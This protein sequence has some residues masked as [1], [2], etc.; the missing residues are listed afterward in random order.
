MH[1][2]SRTVIYPA[3]LSKTEP[4][5]TQSQELHQLIPQHHQ[6]ILSA[7]DSECSVGGALAL[8]AA[9]A[10]FTQE[11]VACVVRSH[12]AAPA[13]W[14]ACPPDLVSAACE[15]LHRNESVLTPRL[16]GLAP[17]RTTRSSTGFWRVTTFSPR[18]HPPAAGSVAGTRHYRE[19]EKVKGRPLG[20]V[21]KYGC[22]GSSRCPDQSGMARRPPTAFKEKSRQGE[23]ELAEE[24]GLTT[25]QRCPMVPRNRRQRDRAADGKDKIPP[26]WQPPDDNRLKIEISNQED[27]PDAGQIR[28]PMPVQNPD[29][30]VELANGFWRSASSS[31]I[32]VG[33]IV[34]FVRQWAA[35]TGVPVRAPAAYAAAARSPHHPVAWATADGSLT[36]RQQQSQHLYAINVRLYSGQQDCR[37]TAAARLTGPARWVTVCTA[38]PAAAPSSAQY[39]STASGT[40]MP[41]IL[42][43]SHH[44]HHLYP[45]HHPGE[46]AAAGRRAV[47]PAASGGQRTRSW[48]RRTPCCFA[49]GLLRSANTEA[50]LQSLRPYAY[51]LQSAE[52]CLQSL[53][54]LQSLEAA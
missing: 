12:G 15:Q 52:A 32:I 10:G 26:A 49:S 43:I 27:L 30:F 51:S 14:T 25:T 48:P 22:G 20:A 17:R 38:A 6:P 47:V 50:G 9:G 7:D 45:F 42:S 11:Q 1:Q 37:V 54:C 2:Q 33:I 3:H 21:A 53:G 28:K 13:T 36:C 40:T 24:T 44:H 35:A 46:A 41:N 16:R 4:T 31:S 29:D 34:N 23:E 8:A 19:E 18:L 5:A 39:S